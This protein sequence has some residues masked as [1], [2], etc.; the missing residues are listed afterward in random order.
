VA[1]ALTSDIVQSGEGPGCFAVA[2]PHFSH[3]A[4]RLNRFKKTP[5]VHVGTAQFAPSRGVGW[6]DRNPALK[7]LDACFERRNIGT[8]HG[9]RRRCDATPPIVPSGAA[10][11]DENDND[12]SRNQG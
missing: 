11:D 10:G 1:T 8:F 5:Q 6:F 7:V 4:P 2:R 3:D 9:G 12:C